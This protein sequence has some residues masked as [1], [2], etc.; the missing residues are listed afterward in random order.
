MKRIGFST[1]ALALSDF[2][3]GLDLTREAQLP[4]I[5]L[6][7]LREA[8]VVPLIEAIP[9][10]PLDTFEFV[11]FHVPSRLQAMSESDLID[12]L[13]VIRDRRWPIVLHPDVISEIDRWAVFEDSVLLENIDQRKRVARTAAEMKPFFDALPNARFCFDIAHARQVDPTMS[14]AVE[15]LMEFGDR[16][17]EIHI[18]ELDGDCRHVAMSSAAVN[19]YQRIS[20]LIPDDVPV[21]IESMIKAEC[22]AQEVG[23]AELALQPKRRRVPLA[24]PV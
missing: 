24:S 14:V 4:A 16:L 19:A 21:I 9:G 6:S 7:A 12:H 3:T 23:M 13:A 5:E 2:Q 15:L 11:S 17:A 10:L 8:E 1:G 22:I 20:S 18:S